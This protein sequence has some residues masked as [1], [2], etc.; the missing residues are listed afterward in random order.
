MS[1]VI[2]DMCHVYMPGTPFEA[3]ALHDINLEIE[4]REFIGLIG[5]TGSGKS[6]LVQHINGLIAPSSGTIIVDGVDLT[7]KDADKRA[8][9]RQVGLVFQYP[10]HQLFEDTV[11]K[12]VAFGPSNLGVKGEERTACVREAIE[13]VG[14]DFAQVRARS[15]FELSG[16]QRRRVAIAGVLAM[17]PSFLIL[18]EPTAGLDPRGRSEV[19]ALVRRLHAQGIGIMMV[20]HSMDDIA[21]VADR[22]IVMNQ[23]TIAMSGTAAEVFARSS[24]LEAMGLDIPDTVRIA[25]L[26]RARGLQV[27]DTLFDIEAMADC[28][29]AQLG[30]KTHA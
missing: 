12:D 9:R 14:L 30:G 26:L 7:R 25:H 8:V 18:D 20:T 2:K 28:I 1:I 3:M 23:G 19:L 17:K 5:H 24:E 11:E 15:P 27:P 16:G 13:Q 4:Q 21:R 29:A 10:E 6:T 22:I